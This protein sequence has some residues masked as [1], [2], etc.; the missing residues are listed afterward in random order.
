MIQQ[1]YLW[2][3]SFYRTENRKSEE[4]TVRAC[5]NRI[6]HNSQETEL[7]YVSVNG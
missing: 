6:I 1:S 5:P 3:C 2:V 4:F 7:T